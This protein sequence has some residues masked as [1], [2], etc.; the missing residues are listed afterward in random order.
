M[1]MKLRCALIHFPLKV[2]VTCRFHASMKIVVDKRYQ[3]CNIPSLFVHCHLKCSVKLIVL[4]QN[5][6]FCVSGHVLQFRGEIRFVHIY[7]STNNL[8]RVC[9]GSYT[10]P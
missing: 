2:L 6:V 1:D 4:L 10:W 3:A 8:Y 9:C 5:F 7:S